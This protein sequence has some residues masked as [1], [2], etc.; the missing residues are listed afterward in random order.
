VA[1]RVI[2]QLGLASGINSSGSSHGIVADDERWATTSHGAPRRPADVSVPQLMSI[3]GIERIGLLKIDIEGGEFAVFAPDED[4]IWLENVDE[5]TMELHPDLGDARGLIDRIRSHNFSVH[6][7]DNAG[8]QVG[9]NSSGLAYAYLRNKRI[10]L[11][12][13]ARSRPR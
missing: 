12:H 11:Y 10:S 2:T 7:R 1:G 3:Y 6:L 4:L 13:H 5:I 9:S 8:S